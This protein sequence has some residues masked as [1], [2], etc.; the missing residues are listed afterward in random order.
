[1][2]N[3]A[4]DLCGPTVSFIRFLYRNPSYCTFEDLPYLPVPQLYRNPSYRT[5]EGR[6]VDRQQLLRILESAHVLDDEMSDRIGE[7]LKG[8]IFDL[9][10]TPSSLYV[11]VSSTLRHPSL[12]PIEIS[13]SHKPP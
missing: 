10:R 3:I 9:Y 4:F 7:G 8:L 5:L 1:M 12:V 6:P 13:N 11:T 2:V